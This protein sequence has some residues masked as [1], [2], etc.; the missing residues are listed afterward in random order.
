[1]KGLDRLM[2]IASRG[3]P[4][5]WNPNP[6]VKDTNR[7]GEGSEHLEQVALIK[8]VH[9][10]MGKYPELASLFAIPNGEHRHQAVA[11]R[12]KLEGVRPGVPDLC[13]PVMRSIYGAFYLEMKRPDLR[14]KRGGKG[15]ISDAQDWWRLRLLEAG[16]RHAVCYTAE[17]AW[18]EIEAYLNLEKSLLKG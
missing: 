7:T 10:N 8:I 16:Y 11:N 1:M 2:G 3:R 9:L 12:L 14:P 6:P 17:E 4:S 5:N 13:L 15:G 18:G